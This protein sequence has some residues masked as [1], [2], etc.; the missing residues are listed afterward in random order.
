[1]VTR[2]SPNPKTAGSSPVVSVNCYFLGVYF[3]KLQGSSVRDLTVPN[4]LRT[5]RF[6]H[7]EFPLWRLFIVNCGNFM[8]EQNEGL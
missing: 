4:A 3:Y 2:P 7:Y 5:Q 1:M 6:L 8:I